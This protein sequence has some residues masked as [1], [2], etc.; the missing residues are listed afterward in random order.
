MAPCRLFRAVTTMCLR[1]RGGV[2]GASVTA[3]IAVLPRDREEE[4][5]FWG[6]PRPR[7]GAAPPCTPREGSLGRPQTPAGGA[8]PLHPQR[9]EPGETPDPGRGRSPLAPPDKGRM[10]IEH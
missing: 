3:V 10:L 9:G 4:K 6:D 5:N 8:A 2:A 7:Q 1:A